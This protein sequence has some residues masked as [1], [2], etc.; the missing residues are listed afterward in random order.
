MK[1]YEIVDE[2]GFSIG[3]RYFETWQEACDARVGMECG[4]SIQEI[5]LP[6]DE[7]PYFQIVQT[8]WEGRDTRA[9]VYE[10]AEEANEV[11]GRIMNFLEVRSAVINY[12]VGDDVKIIAAF[13]R[14]G[15]KLEGVAA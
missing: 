1:A 14:T 6:C 7:P 9:E 2:A 3:S 8:N 10:S 11:F 5:E 4:G 13:N 15:L 12:W